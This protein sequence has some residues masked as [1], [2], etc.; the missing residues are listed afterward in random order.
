M[1]LRSTVSAVLD[2]EILKKMDFLR[3]SLPVLNVSQACLTFLV[4][5][6]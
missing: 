1:T 3:A 6:V 4:S 2:S 5:R